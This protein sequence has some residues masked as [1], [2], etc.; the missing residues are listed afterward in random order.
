VFH[1]DMGV[2]NLPTGQPTLVLTGGALTRLRLL[3]PDGYHPSL[4][5]TL[6]DEPPYAFAQVIIQAVPPG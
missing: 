1:G 6:T 2:V 5:L 3:M 4:L